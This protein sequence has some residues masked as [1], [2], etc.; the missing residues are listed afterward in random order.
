MPQNPWRL[1]FGGMIALAVG[2]GV[3]RFVYTP[4]LPVMVEELG[5]SVSE[6]GLIASANYLG[7]LVGALLSSLSFFRGSRRSYMLVALTVNAV[8]LA[9]MGL[10]ADFSFHLVVRFVG[11]VA[12]AFV[13]IFASALVLERLAELGRGQ[14]PALHFA[15]V[16]VG[17]AISAVIVAALLAAG[18]DWRTLWYASGLTAIGGLALAALLISEKEPPPKPAAAGGRAPASPALR[19][20]IVAYGL[21]GFGYVI[22]ATFIVAIVRDAPA[23]SAMEPYVWALFGLSAAPSVA[24]WLRIGARIGVIPAFAIACFVEAV[25]VASSILWVSP[26][27]IVVA[28]VFLGATMIGI[29]ALGLIAV[30]RLSTGDPRQT[31]ALTTASFGLGQVIGPAFAGFLGDY[32][33]SLA[34][35]SLV[36]AGALVVAAGLGW[37]ASVSQA[38]SGLPIRASRKEHA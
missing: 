14:L 26:T 27:G 25:G 15:G 11:G 34:V 29:T 9:A 5:L 31:V 37:F 10:L 12:S 1:T 36:A 33:G 22:T 2:Q 4:I 21:F 35:P 8:G 32:L 24:L 28:V 7:Y 38:R 23:V 13:L 16:G 18:A 30:Q 17:I 6:A 3:G 19:A 20:M